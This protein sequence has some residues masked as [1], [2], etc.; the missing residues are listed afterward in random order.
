MWSEVVSMCEATGCDR[1]SYA[2]GHCTRHYKQLLR[3]GHVLPE[4]A[5]KRCAVP[6][7]ERQAAARGW[8]HGHYLRWTRTGELR[9]DVPLQRRP[10]ACCVVAGCTR[11]ATN[12]GMCSAHRYRMNV[13]DDPQADVPV[14]T[15]RGEGFV[16][17]GYRVVPVPPDKRWLTGGLTS[18]AEHRL[19]MAEALGRPL[20]SQE[21]VHHRN[22]DRRDNRIENLELWSRFQPNGQRV[23]DKITWALQIL[24]LYDED[25]A[26]ALGLDLV[27]DTGLPGYDVAG[28]S[29]HVPP[30]GFEPT[31]TP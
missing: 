20:S 8:C 25:A 2:R 16:H 12:L 3:H 30:M 28:Q 23:Q 24:R 6:T 21:S 10:R 29:L 22:G 17:Q 13:H 26:R 7:C 19:V 27:P 14:A 5:V 1:K 4:R 31:P 15:P 9:P 18:V 11:A